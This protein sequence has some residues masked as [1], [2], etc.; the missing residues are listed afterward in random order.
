MSLQLL[1]LSNG[2]CVMSFSKS[3]DSVEK[4]H[5]VP[6]ILSARIDDVTY[7]RLWVAAALCFGSSIVGRWSSGPAISET[8]Y[9]AVSDYL[10]GTGFFHVGNVVR[11]TPEYRTGV[12]AKLVR[13]DGLFS[14]QK[15]PESTLDD[16]FMLLEVVPL[17]DWSG[18]LFN[19]HHFLIASNSFL[20]DDSDIQRKYAGGSLAAAIL[21]S[22]DLSIDEIH[23]DNSD[24]SPGAFERVGSLLAAVGLK[25]AKY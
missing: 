2:R 23:V 9:L 16:E 1:N 5:A 24:W 12:S 6:L 17:G 18:A 15:R 25:L 20:H 3:E 19:L 4:Y 21:L 11:E 13:S 8:A 22:N 7:D 10:R 14:N